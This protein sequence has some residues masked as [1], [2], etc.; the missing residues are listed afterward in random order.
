MTT[1][2]HNT[3]EL[4]GEAVKLAIEAARTQEE[5]VEAYFRC[6][7]AGHQATAEEVHEKIF[8]WESPTQIWSTRA[9]ISTLVKKEVL[10][11]TR[12]KVDG[13]FGRPVKKYRLL[14][15]GQMELL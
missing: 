4:T 14:A 2:F 1:P 3:T 12:E 13:A 7:P 9:R 5:K 11:I 6:H 8:G 15:Q 10:E